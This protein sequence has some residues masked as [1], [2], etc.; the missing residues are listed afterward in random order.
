MAELAAVIGEIEKLMD[1]APIP[2]ETHEKDVRGFK[3][4][5]QR[6]PESDPVAAGEA[7]R[8]NPTSHQCKGPSTMQQTGN[9]C[10]RSLAGADLIFR[11][12]STAPKVTSDPKMKFESKAKVLKSWVRTKREQQRHSKW[13]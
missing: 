6:D 11:P 7:T 13:S 9:G 1:K 12:F 10:S 4:K 5:V 3:E 2:T 8:V